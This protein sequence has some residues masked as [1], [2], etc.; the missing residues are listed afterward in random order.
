VHDDQDS[1][2]E[3]NSAVNHTN[4]EGEHYRAVIDPDLDDADQI[5]D[6]SLTW[7]TTAW[8]IEHAGAEF[9]D[10]LRSATI[11]I[12]ASKN[13]DPT[14]GDCRSD[15]GEVDF[16]LT[17]PY[18]T[19]SLMADILKLDFDI[20]LEQRNAR[21]RA[22]HTWAVDNT[23]LML[24]K[25][26][27]HYRA[28]WEPLAGYI[29]KTREIKDPTSEHH[30]DSEADDSGS[31]S[32]ASTDQTFASRH[33]MCSCSETHGNHGCNVELNDD[34]MADGITL[35]PDCRITTD[36]L[37]CEC[38]CYDCYEFRSTVGTVTFTTDT[39]PADTNQGAGGH[40][41]Q[42]NDQDS[43]MDQY[44]NALASARTNLEACRALGLDQMNRNV[45]NH[46]A[47]RSPRANQPHAE[48]NQQLRHESALARATTAA[49]ICTALGLDLMGRSVENNTDKQKR[50]LAS[51]QL[52]SALAREEQMTVD[53]EAS[54]RKASLTRMQVYAAGASRGARKARAFVTQVEGNGRITGVDSY[55]EISMVLDTIVNPSWTILEDEG[56]SLRGIGRANT[57]PLVKV[58]VSY[59]CGMSPRYITMRVA[60]ASIMPRGIELLIGTRAQYSDDITIDSGTNRIII[61]KQSVVID[62]EPVS[63]IMTRQRSKPL[64]V[65]ELAGG[66][67]PALLILT[68]LGWRIRKYHS[69]EN[70]QAAREVALSNAKHAGV[71]LRHIENL[72]ELAE[73]DMKIPYDL[74]LA[75]PP[76]RQ[77]SR[78]R[79]SPKGWDSEDG[80]L[81][82]ICCCIINKQKSMGHEPLFLFENVVLHETRAHD[83]N[84]QN[85]YLGM[86]FENL[87]A[88]DCGGTQQRQR[89]IAT[90]ICDITALTKMAPADPNWMLN[91]TASTLLRIMPSAMAIGSKTR[92][93]V[94]VTDTTTGEERLATAEELER[95]Q[96]YPAGMTKTAT[97]IERSRMLGNSWNYHQM[98]RVFRELTRGADSP[99][100][101][102]I[103]ELEK[104]KMSNE[105][106]AW[107]DM[108]TAEQFTA[109]KHK[110]EGYKIPT[111]YITV[112]ETENV[113][114]QVPI[115]ERARTTP[116][117][118]P[119]ARAE[120]R[121]RMQRGHIKLVTYSRDQ[122]VSRM[123][124]K[125]KDRINPE[126]GMEAIRFLTD[127]RELNKA[128]Q[129]PSQWG[130]ECP[131]IEHVTSTIPRD[132]RYYAGEDIKDAY[133]GV[134]MDQR[135]RHLV[136]VAP[137]FEVLASDYT[138]E[139]LSQFSDE[140][141]AKLRA[142]TRP[143][144]LQWT[145]MPQGLASAAP[146][147]NVHLA[148]GFNQ[149]FG[150]MWRDMLAIYVD[151]LLIHGTTYRHC[152][153]RQQLIHNALRALGKE[154][155]AKCDRSIKTYG[156]IVGL[157]VTK[158][159][160][161]PDDGVMEA[162]GQELTTV[163]TTKKK[164]Q[165]L[166]G[167]IRYSHTAFR[168]TPDDLLWYNKAMQPM[169]ESVGADTFT[170]GQD[171]KDAVSILQERMTQMPRAHSNPENMLDDTHCLVMISDACDDGV[172]AALWTVLRNNA[173]DVTIDDLHNP[174]V[175]MLMAIDSKILD[176]GQQKWATFE[177]EMYGAYRGMKKWG[178]LM[179]Q[180][181]QKCKDRTVCKISIRMDN[182]TATKQWID[183]QNPGIIDFAG[184]KEMRFLGW[185]EKMSFTRELNIDASY[186]PG[187]MNSFADLVSRIAQKLGDAAQRK[188]HREYD[189]VVAHTEVHTFSSESSSHNGEVPEGY[190]C[191]H[192]RMTILES[193]EVQRAQ[194]HD[195][196]TVHK[197]RL[198][199]VAKCV[200]GKDEQVATE[201]SQKVMPW[202]GRTYYRITHPET[203]T[204]LV[205]T[206]VSQHRVQWEQED[207]TKILV[208]QVPNGARV[209]L[210]CADELFETAADDAP[211]WI[212]KQTELKGQMLSLAHDMQIPHPTVTESV[213]ML[214]R[215][216]H[217][218]RMLNDMME[219]VEFCADCSENRKHRE[220]AGAGIVSAQ[221]LKVIQMDHYLLTTEQKEACGVELVL[222]ITCTA[223]QITS[224]EMVTHQTALSTAKT[225]WMRWIPFYGVPDMVITDPHP[226]F[227][228]EIM[229]H[230]RSFMG[231]KDHILAASGSKSKTGM[232]ETR[233]NELTAALSDGFAKGAITNGEDLA[234]YLATA[235][236]RH[237]QDR[238]GSRITPFECLTG[239]KAASRMN[240]AM[241][242]PHSV[243]PEAL[244]NQS[245]QFCEMIKQQTAHLMSINLWKRDDVARSNTR[246]RHQQLGKN[247]AHTHYDLREGADVSFQGNLYKLGKT[248][249]AAI[250]KPISAEIHADGKARKVQFKD[251][252]PAA[253]PRPANYLRRELPQIGKLIIWEGKLNLRAGI[254]METDL[255]Q[256]TVRVHEHA[257]TQVSS[258]YWLPLWKTA[259]GTTV[260]AK[261]APDNTEQK[262]V[263]VSSARIKITGDLM[264]TFALS[265]PTKKEA[266]AKLAI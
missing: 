242:K 167:V 178:R 39:V 19:H 255:Q 71:K 104:I 107:H 168:W 98:S 31:T 111:H 260:R 138:D 86:S 60:S 42:P 81:F 207:A 180:A 5:P 68:D 177:K 209:K 181:M 82:K 2:R 210:T 214:K 62:T 131:T 139:E 160:I 238:E 137:P 132:A 50:I 216:G 79:S 13:A 218:S 192:L 201:V 22:S 51:K 171:C 249:G 32:D 25:R 35:C 220:E 116:A 76:C 266:M 154:L 94:N 191:R 92:A 202:I 215:M 169:H 128:I 80:E 243:I 119:A 190:T 162:L 236:K 61:K 105:E 228:S 109:I 206:P 66:T 151:D 144:L 185:A 155:S 96:G 59:R 233:H 101:Y 17:T 54:R 229:S 47:P 56:I 84:T 114:Y 135:S 12:D 153:L 33:D 174:D 172:G 108:N 72:L 193:Q 170:W 6:N 188:K 184:P 91:P 63:H 28:E 146:F 219:H 133:E 211:T 205:Y 69:S 27:P 149:I 90:N 142:S 224:Y 157:K 57:G 73:Q 88:S 163:P 222:T 223:T 75:S 152:E 100:I 67:S 159:G 136:T 140:P 26:G 70:N 115:R 199:D 11:M 261:A 37:E 30:I 58:P 134:N 264:K 20:P 46:P 234:M 250:N 141:I 143:L 52:H 1:E 15:G 124:T 240:L 175:S 3:Q 150:E 112:K 173:K 235:K 239:Q 24:Y 44:S 253:T 23:Q 121:L 165:H 251:L 241:V 74:I 186:I 204:K 247:P 110:L 252:R 230:L 225:L 10:A 29:Q 95:L 196:E 65:L 213:I 16:D 217:W 14:T 106:R 38:D 99:G 97:P 40:P 147:F 226:G 194:L 48:V 200:L 89:R 164:A 126:T 123:F 166:I 203:Q 227:A 183:M 118:E 156:N 43:V 182:S 4:S 120:L 189:T 195:P 55:A 64:D 212:K 237:D 77:F 122:W 259:E 262:I 221:R 145:G 7:E 176:K 49:E 158:H 117:R 36:R 256:Q 8:S 34:E 254:V 245:K 125:G 113:P 78:A 18:T 179:I 248:T 127:L 41:T 232:V 161:E 257:A 9:H 208:L 129:W 102:H 246:R 85:E 53:I 198:S 45:G 244:D 258:K 93:P 21:L 197:I 130:D 87:R 83:A 231:I 187:N 265:P 263:S 103:S 148:D